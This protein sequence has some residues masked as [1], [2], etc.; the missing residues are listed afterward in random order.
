VFNI[1][2]FFWVFWIFWEDFGDLFVDFLGGFW[3]IVLDIFSLLVK[4]HF[5]YKKPGT[6]ISN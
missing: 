4:I 5:F 6:T 2:D 1:W 3:G